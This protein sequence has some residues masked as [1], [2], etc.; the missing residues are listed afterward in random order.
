MNKEYHFPNVCFHYTLI[1]FQNIVL[2]PTEMYISRS[3]SQIV[4]VKQNAKCPNITV[5]SIFINYIFQ[6]PVNFSFLWLSCVINDLSSLKKYI[7]G[8]KRNKENQE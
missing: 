7:R 8:Y 1:I 4:L 3:D 6:N 2:S 5:K